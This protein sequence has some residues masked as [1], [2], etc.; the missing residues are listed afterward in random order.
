MQ[1]H[2]DRIYIIESLQPGETLTGTNLHT[3]LLRDKSSIHPDFESVLRNPADKSEW[4]QLFAEIA[5]DCR[6]NG[7]SPIIHFEVHGDSMKRG[8]VLTSKELVTWEELYQNLA[9]I[10]LAIRNELFV[11]MAVC[12][13]NFW[14]SSAV[15]NRPAAF[16]GM[17]GSFHKLYE[18]DLI[19][20]FDAFYRELFSSFDLNKAY[21]ALK[22]ANPSL[23]DHYGCYSAEEIFALAFTGYEK[24]YCSPESLK[25]RA[26]AAI[27]A[28]GNMNRRER[29]QFERSFIKEELKKHEPYFRHCYQTFFMLD[30]FPELADTIGFGNSLRKMKD[31]FN[32]V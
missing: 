13:G 27:A 32:H 18:D 26:D 5:E 12:F 20:R 4:N 19:I 25:A 15:L 21:D 11:T 1:I 6:R 3:S 14:L 22:R 28:N 17:V 24:S 16:R 7:H 8:L 23:P 31:W 9:P 10:N 30:R 2:F 29:R